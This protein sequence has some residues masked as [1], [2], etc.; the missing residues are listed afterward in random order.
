MLQILSFTEARADGVQQRC[1]PV[2]KR[3]T[4]ADLARVAGVSVATIDRVL[5]RRH[6]VREETARRVL[7][8][9][10]EIGFHATALIRQRLSADAP[11]RTFGFVL[12]KETH[13]FYQA[14]AAALADAVRAAPGVRGHPLVTFAAELTPAATLEKL[15]TV[16]SQA[17]AVG[18]VS[19]DHP[20][21]S[22]AIEDLR[23]RGVPTFGLL[24][25]LTTPAWAGYV[26]IDNRKAGRLAAWT[27]ARTARQPGEVGILVGSHRYLG[28]EMREIGFR[29]YFREH[30][31]SFQ[32]LEA[33]VN[34]EEPRIAYEATLDLLRKH[35][36]LVG[37]CV[38]GGGMEGVIAALRDE[39]RA[40]TLSVVVN[41]LTPDT[42]A[43]LTDDIVTLAIGT[44][45]P[46]LAHTIVEAM[47]HAMEGGAS[48][49]PGQFVLPFDIYTSENF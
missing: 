40:G 2:S 9:A 20:G 17:H 29:S 34:L 15:A 5:N 23:Q 8:A 42:R 49:T 32:V 11:N 4:I 1:E 16:G 3:P 26:G 14:L 24:T 25:G 43:A 27:I 41:E 33:I 10:E 48:G 44:P 35:P 39:G 12:Q 46:L 47:I 37:I 22:E 30:A 7:E 18:I 38:A 28:H 13:F 31:P 45:I 6:P 21:I 19:V 36:T